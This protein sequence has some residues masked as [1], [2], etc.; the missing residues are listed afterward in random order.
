MNV[1]V[2]QHP[3]LDGDVVKDEEVVVVTMVMMVVM[4]VAIVVVGLVVVF[5]VAFYGGQCCH[6]YLLYYSR[7]FATVWMPFQPGCRTTKNCP[8]HLVVLVSV[9]E[10][11]H[12][13]PNV[14]ES[15]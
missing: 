8:R 13:K 10:A 11:P 5:V 1:P 4:V 3:A 15:S 7:A 6:C 14:A 2:K 12:V 9:N